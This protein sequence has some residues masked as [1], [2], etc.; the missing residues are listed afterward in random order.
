MT[1]STVLATPVS[2]RKV[3]TRAGRGDRVTVRTDRGSLLDVTLS[4]ANG[5]GFASPRSSPLGRAL[6][7]RGVGDFVE[8]KPG[9][10]GVVLE[11]R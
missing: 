1:A 5:V 11:I 7:G 2:A 8:V 4:D 3:K 10:L 6:F 9:R